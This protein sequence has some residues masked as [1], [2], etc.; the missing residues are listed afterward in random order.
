MFPQ[1]KQAGILDVSRL[2]NISQDEL[3]NWTLGTNFSMPGIKRIVAL[4]TVAVFALF[5]FMSSTVEAKGPKITNKV[6]DERS[7]LCIEGS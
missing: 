5:F 1:V 7:C 4:A 6:G 2:D 3:I